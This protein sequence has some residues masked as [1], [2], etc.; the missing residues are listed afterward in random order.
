[1]EYFHWLT[2]VPLLGPL[3]LV[4]QGETSFFDALPILATGLGACLICA[5]IGAFLGV[6]V[7]LRRIV[8]VSAAISQVASL[9]LALAMW[10]LELIH[11]AALAPPAGA[12]S[13]VSG[14]GLAAVLAAAAAA[15]LFAWRGREQRLTRESV[16]GIAYVL[17][18]G[19][20]LLILDRLASETHLIENVLFGNTVFVDSQQLQAL[21]AI[22]ALVS[23]AHL[24]LFKEFI[25]VAFDRDVA[26]AA[27][28]PVVLYDQ[29]FY[30][31]LALTISFAI[32]AIGA[33]PVFGFMVMPAAAALLL[34]SRLRLA[35]ALAVA[36]GVFAAFTGF[37]L[38]F[39]FALPTGPAM[40]AVA[41]ACLL[42]GLLRRAI[43]GA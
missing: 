43:K 30:L 21:A 35:F 3:L 16:L 11:G 38:S 42:P 13:M 25:A 8:F 19:L 9:G 23:A 20:V 26:G 41:G 12:P 5:A 33:L 31:S 29:L 34:T 6:H 14:P 18:A 39:V 36:I 4:R 2:A 28:M 24:L 15:S 40:L 27:G 22:A 1:M 10:L 37:Y 17:P 7:I 32:G